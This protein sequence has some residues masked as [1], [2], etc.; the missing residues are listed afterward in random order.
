M[1]DTCRTH[2]CILMSPDQEKPKIQDHEPER[3]AHHPLGERV[4]ERAGV[5]G[6]QQPF[7]SGRRLRPAV[8]LVQP[9][10]AISPP[11][12]GMRSSPIS[13]C[14]LPRL[15]SIHANLVGFGPAVGRSSSNG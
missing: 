14:R 4:R 1:P 3:N 9:D 7:L 10:T 15:K 13:S 11:R 5:G 6:R 8:V 2:T 12:N